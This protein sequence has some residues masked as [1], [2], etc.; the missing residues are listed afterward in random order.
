[1]RRY[2]FVVLTVMALLALTGCRS[3]KVA[4]SLDGAHPEQARYES[5]V[6]NR[7]DYDAL[8]S[9]TRFSLGST[10]LNGKMCLESGKRL[11]LQVNAPLLGFEIARVEASQQSVLVVDKYDKLYCEERLADLYELDELKGHEMEALECIVLGRIYL[12]GRGV[13]SA[14]DYKMLNWSTPTLP[15]GAMGNTIGV[16]TGRN[17]SLRYDIAPNGRLASTQLTV[18]NRSLLLEYDEYQEVGKDQWVPV[19]E[20][21]TA[22]G[23]DGKQIK[24]GLTLNNPE[25]GE[26]TWR[27]FEPTSGYRKVTASELVNKVKG[28]VK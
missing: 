16:Y 10:S 24:A 4:S 21:I 17:Y 11:C 18:G 12:P 8:Q 22:T 6:R 3:S 7:F 27:D 2:K 23:S 25:T 20:T 26:S 14:R 5:V 13:A 1:M 15:N 28:M 9:K 19:R